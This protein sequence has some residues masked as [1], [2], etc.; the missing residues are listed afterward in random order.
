VHTLWYSR[1][2]SGFST[3]EEHLVLLGLAALTNALNL[4]YATR[5]TYGMIGTTD[6]ARFHVLP[7][8]KARGVT[9]GHVSERRCIHGSSVTTLHASNPS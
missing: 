2:N 1:K 6:N 5:S 9:P 7:C 8:E 3:Q 4:R